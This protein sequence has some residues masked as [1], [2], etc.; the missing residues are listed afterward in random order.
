[1]EYD[2]SEDSIIG[3]S[4]VPT[5]RV[6]QVLNDV[7][8][9][10]NTMS[11]NDRPLRIYYGGEI[12]FG[13]SQEELKPLDVYLMDNAVAHA[14]LLFKRDE[15]ESGEFWTDTGSYRQYFDYSRD[16]LELKGI[17]NSVKLTLK[18]NNKY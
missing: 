9:K 15:I 16:T 7:I 14:A 13:V 2:N 3:I 5:E 1:M 10:M 8:D 11:Y 17:V 18:R 4:W 12:T 6:T